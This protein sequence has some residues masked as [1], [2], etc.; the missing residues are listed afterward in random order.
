MCAYGFHSR[1]DRATCRYV[2]EA[3]FEE[4]SQ[5]DDLRKQEEMSQQQPRGISNQPAWK[6]REFQQQEQQHLANKE[7]EVVVAE[8]EEEQQALDLKSRADLD[9]EAMHSTRYINNMLDRLLLNPRWRNGQVLQLAT[10][11]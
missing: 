4:L 10:V 1:R 3:C 11:S 5:Q 9:K 7:Q 2:C 6:V 8:Q